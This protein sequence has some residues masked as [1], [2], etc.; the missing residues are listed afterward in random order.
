MDSAKSAGK[1]I[2]PSCVTKPLLSLLEL[3][4]P[5]NRTNESCSLVSSNAVVPLKTLILVPDPDN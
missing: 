5:S 1:P 3:S 2:P 4:V